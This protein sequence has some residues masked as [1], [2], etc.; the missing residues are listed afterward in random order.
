M[1]VRVAKEQIDLFEITILEQSA[2]LEALDLV[3]L[4]EHPSTDPVVFV[5]RSMTRERA[6]TIRSIADAVFKSG[7]VMLIVPPFADN[8]I[9]LYVDAR[10][11]IRVV[12]RPPTSDCSVVTPEWQA[13][14]G[15]KLNI[16]SD[17]HIETAL[18]AGETCLDGDGKIVLL[19]YQPKNTSGAVFVSTLQLLSYTA[20]TDESDRNVLIAEVL[21]WR[22]LQ[23]A[24]AHT[25]EHTFID[26]HVPTRE[27]LSMVLLAI[28]A[29]SSLDS[30]T[31]QQTTDTYFG[32]HLSDHVISRVLAYL[33]SEGVIERVNEQSHTKIADRRLNE[34]IEALGLHAYARELRELVRNGMEASG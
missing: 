2:E 7:T 10:L 5:G 1:K 12:R 11:S 3:D 16:R 34:A 8:D 20:L 17:H 22:N 27:E 14:L 28:V 32:G 18:T 4:A 26:A 31:L 29:S 30:N 23:V 25:V 6:A 9:S 21:N 13:R 33:E 15:S 24:S 19:R